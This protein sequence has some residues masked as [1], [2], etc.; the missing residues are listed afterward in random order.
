MIIL[1][2]YVDTKQ[3]TDSG[4]RKLH[5]LFLVYI[6]GLLQNMSWAL[7]NVYQLQIL[8]NTFGKL[9]GVRNRRYY[10]PPTYNNRDGANLEARGNKKKEFW[11][12]G[13]SKTHTDII[14]F[15]VIN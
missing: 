8:P 10:Y 4:S 6:C 3:V 11:T 5:S 15:T 7:W 9:F 13:G 14:P 12:H 2:S 1:P